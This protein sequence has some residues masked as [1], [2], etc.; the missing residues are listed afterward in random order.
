MK[1]VI[2]ALFTILIFIP[3]QSRAQDNGAAIA[4]AAVALT[5]IGVGIA[6]TAGAG[7]TAFAQARL[8]AD[9]GGVNE[10]L[11]ADS[12]VIGALTL[13][14]HHEAW[15]DYSDTGSIASGAAIGSFLTIVL[16]GQSNRVGAANNTGVG[17]DNIRLTGPAPIPEP[18]STALLGLGGLALILRRRR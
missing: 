13:A 3:K 5:A 18:S 7:D 9:W 4:G 15:A 12:G 17:L 14:A 11:V 8:Y 16:D 10:T 1:K 2:I 6:G